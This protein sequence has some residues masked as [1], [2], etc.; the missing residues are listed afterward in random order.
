MCFGSPTPFVT[1]NGTAAGGTAVLGSDGLYY[2]DLPLCDDQ[3]GDNDF[4]DTRQ[5]RR[6]LRRLPVHQLRELRGGH[7]GD[8]HAGFRQ[9]AVDVHRVVHHDSQRPQGARLILI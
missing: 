2:G 3:D 9:H 6:G 4:D 8:V 7:V 5:D 1:Q